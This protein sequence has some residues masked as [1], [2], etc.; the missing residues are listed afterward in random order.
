MYHANSNQK[1][2]GTFLTSGKVDFMA[3]IS[4]R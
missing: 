1:T 4:Q 3:E 2:K